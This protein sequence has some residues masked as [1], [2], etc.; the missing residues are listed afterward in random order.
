MD[1]TLYALLKKEIEKATLDSSQ[2]DFSD[3]AKK[4]DLLKYASKEDVDNLTNEISNLLDTINGEE[5]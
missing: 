5:V 1:L 3:F 4:E 2:L